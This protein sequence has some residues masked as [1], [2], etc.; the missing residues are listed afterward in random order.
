M[1]STINFTH[2]KNSSVK[3]RRI[4]CTLNSY[5]DQFTFSLLS[6]QYSHDCVY[7]CGKSTF[8]QKE[9]DVCLMGGLLQNTTVY[10]SLMACWFTVME[11]SNWPWK[12]TRPYPQLILSLHFLLKAAEIKLV[13]QVSWTIK[14]IPK[15]IKIPH[16]P[17]HSSSRLQMCACDVDIVAALTSLWLHCESLSWIVKVRL[18]LG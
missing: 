16:V 12:C 11:G 17:M 6:L 14:N 3:C 1:S 10:L 18:T 7:V 8:S 13:N 4:E 15:V 5:L 2:I 9:V